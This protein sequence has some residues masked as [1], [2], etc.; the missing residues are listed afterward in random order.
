ME[1]RPPSDV[2]DRKAAPDASSAARP[3]VLDVVAADLSLKNWVSAPGRGSLDDERKARQLEIERWKNEVARLNEALLIAEAQ[4]EAQSGMARTL[5]SATMWVEGNRADMTTAQRKLREAQER[6]SAFQPVLDANR[7]DLIL[8]PEWLCPLDED[9][10]RGAWH[11][12]KRP[13]YF[14]RLSTKFG[15]AQTRPKRGSYSREAIGSYLSRIVA[16]ARIIHDAHLLELAGVSRVQDRPEA[17]DF[18]DVAFVVH[19][20]LTEHGAKPAI[21]GEAQATLSEMQR[22]ADEELRRWADMPDEPEPVVPVEERVV[23]WL[24]RQAAAQPDRWFRERE[25]R[26]AVLPQGTDGGR[27]RT[28]LERLVEEFGVIQRRSAAGS[29]AFEYHA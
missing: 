1:A 11:W 10:I 20:V 23:E 12:S 15:R 9:R 3:P 24:T 28:V 14:V 21:P 6:M 2:P 26:P 18:R 22:Y 27:V 5:S 7:A 8:A 16:R 17:P 19:E 4:L 29:K 13:D 25:I